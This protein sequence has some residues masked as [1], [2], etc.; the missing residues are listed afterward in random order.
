M[1]CIWIL[2]DRLKDRLTDI[3]ISTKY[4][5]LI[6]NICTLQSFRWIFGGFT[7]G[8][9]NLVNA[10]SMVWA[11]K[12][13]FNPLFILWKVRLYLQSCCNFSCRWL[14]SKGELKPTALMMLLWRRNGDGGWQWLPANMGRNILYKNHFVFCSVASLSRRLSNCL[15]KRANWAHKS[16]MA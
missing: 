1:V 8:I 11:I 15:R 13:T 3:A 5:L 2:T 7:I 16:S 12:K 4:F 14:A 10:L 9:T 6:T